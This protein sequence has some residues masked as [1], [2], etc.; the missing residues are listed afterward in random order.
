MLIDVKK[1][2][3]EEKLFLLEEI[4]SSMDEI[5]SPSWHNEVLE[6]RNDF[7]NKK[8]YTIKELKD[9]FSGKRF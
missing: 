1:L 8:T 6:K 7:K 3:L 4:L 2:K 5:D 9:E